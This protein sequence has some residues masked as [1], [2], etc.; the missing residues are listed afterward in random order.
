MR[1]WHGEYLKN[2]RDALAHRT[3][4]SI[5]PAMYSTEDESKYIALQE[6]WMQSIKMRDW[7]RADDIS[8]AQASLGIPCFV[9]AHSLDTAEGKPTNYIHPQ[10]MADAMTAAE[11]CT[12]VAAGYFR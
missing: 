2:F 10:M 7:G 6:Q 11:A 3:A 8:H 5:P 9:F 4:P 1:M 12:P